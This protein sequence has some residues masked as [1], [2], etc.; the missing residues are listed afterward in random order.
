MANNRLNKTIAGYHILMILSAVDFRF[1]VE[2]EII[3]KEFLIHE[4]PLPIS[5]DKQ[6]DIIS[7]LLPEEWET[8]FEKCL[9][10]FYDDATER[11]RLDF[12]KFALELIKADDII[13]KEENKFIQLLFEKWMFEE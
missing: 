10:D 11:E 4:F 5:L 1:V 2:E 8:H 9:D 7:S 13:T 12:I 3:I 6:M